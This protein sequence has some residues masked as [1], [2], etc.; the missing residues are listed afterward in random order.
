MVNYDK[1]TF[2]TKN[3]CDKST[4]CTTKQLFNNVCAICCVFFFFFLA[5]FWKTHYFLPKYLHFGTKNAILSVKK[6]V[7]FFLVFSEKRYPF[8]AIRRALKLDSSFL[9]KIKNTLPRLKV[10]DLYARAYVKKE[11]NP[12]AT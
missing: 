3:Q 10:L 2:C 4:F 7:N 9:Y 12:L 5:S 1:S 11:A 6:S 8:S